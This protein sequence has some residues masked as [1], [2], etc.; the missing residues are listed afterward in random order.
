[1]WKEV[2]SPVPHEFFADQK[3]GS[4]AAG[5]DAFKDEFHF[6]NLLESKITIIGVPED[7][8]SPDQKGTSQAPKSIR[9][10]FYKLVSGSWDI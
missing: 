10:E 5:I 3:P 6:P 8:S 9:K 2:L 1:M 4:I 7:R